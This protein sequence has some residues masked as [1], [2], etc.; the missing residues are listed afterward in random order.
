MSYNFDLMRKLFF[1]GNWKCN[2]TLA[3]TQGLVGSLL[4]KLEFDPQEAGNRE[5]IQML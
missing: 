4:D 5:T 1:G 3:Q 2:N